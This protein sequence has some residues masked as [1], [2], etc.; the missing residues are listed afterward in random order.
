MK[1]TSV[2]PVIEAQQANLVEQPD[3][4]PVDLSN[5]SLKPWQTLTMLVRFKP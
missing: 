4:G 3:G 5:L 2:F 1:L